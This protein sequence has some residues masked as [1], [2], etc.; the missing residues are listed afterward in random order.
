MLKNDRRDIGNSMS[1]LANAVQQHYSTR[2]VLPLIREQLRRKG[3]AEDA[4]R[5]EDLYPYDQSHAG[6]VAATRRLAQRAVI[7][8]DSLLVEVGCGF[9]SSSRLLHH[10]HGCRVVGI[11]LTP[12]R[13]ATA[14]E[15]TRM[16]RFEKGVRFVVGSA[17]AL[18]LA[19]SV[20]DVVWTQHVTMNLP[21]HAAFVRECAR[22]LKPSGR[23]A[24][25]EWLRRKG[26]ALPSPVPWAPVPELN[27]AVEDNVLM[28]LL[29]KQGLEPEAEDVTDA[30]AAA[31]VADAKTLDEQDYPPE[32][33]LPLKNLVKAAGDGLVGCW[34]IVSRRR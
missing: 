23:M 31:L 33:T 16:L 28:A 18:P 13:I 19:P 5:P 17:L 26:G 8:R 2:P 7:A 27:C 9:G 10:E 11:D 3:I 1:N 32:R 21:D 22:V 29:R 6:G 14:A 25:H 20:A 30:M 24:S 12:S 15:L 4:V 34:M